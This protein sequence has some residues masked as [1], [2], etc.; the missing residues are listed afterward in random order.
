[1]TAL[2]NP[3]NAGAAPLA[4]HLLAP[5]GGAPTPE[6][7]WAA[8]LGHPAVDA[9]LAQQGDALPASVLTAADPAADGMTLL[10]HCAHSGLVRRPRAA[11]A[12]SVSDLPCGLYRFIFY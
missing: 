8:A 11:A 9:L 5:G 7:F 10:H 4:A 6:L 12:Q 2:N 3:L 1:M